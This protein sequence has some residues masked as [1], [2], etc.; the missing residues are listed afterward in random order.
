MIA[1]ITV[2]LKSKFILFRKNINLIENEFSYVVSNAYRHWMT[3]KTTQ[4]NILVCVVYFLTVYC[5]SVIFFS[6]STL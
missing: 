5:F 1:F 4:H 2:I 6:N 3:K